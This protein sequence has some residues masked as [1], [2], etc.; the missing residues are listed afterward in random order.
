MDL[1]LHP[2]A[3]LHPPLFPYLLYHL[4]PLLVSIL[5]VPCPMCLDFAQ[6][7]LGSGNIGGDILSPSITGLFSREAYTPVGVCGLP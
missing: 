4:V 2:P 1:T 5:P 7:N 3:N 6:D